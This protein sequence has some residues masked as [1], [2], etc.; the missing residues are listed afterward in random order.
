MNSFVK[1]IGNLLILL[2]GLF[3]RFS[4]R[5]TMI[6]PA[7]LSESHIS[8]GAF[9]IRTLRLKPNVRVPE[10]MFLRG[11]KPLRII[12]PISSVAL[13]GHWLG[14][15]CK[16]CFLK[17][18]LTYAC[19]CKYGSTWRGICIQTSS[20]VGMDDWLALLLRIRIGLSSDLYFWAK[21]GIF[22]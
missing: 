22:P 16:Y 15:S 6:L 19:L 4:Y 2:A 12:R 11:R 20:K 14:I 18:A 21:W 7:N 13:T 8:V 1:Y 17:R 10:N 9:Y 3:I 5:H